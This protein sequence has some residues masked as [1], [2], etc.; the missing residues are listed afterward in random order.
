MDLI[1]DIIIVFGLVSLLF[2]VAGIWT[3]LGMLKKQKCE[4]A[5]APESP[6]KKQ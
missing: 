1:W 6:T 2:L 3:Y 4:D 5:K